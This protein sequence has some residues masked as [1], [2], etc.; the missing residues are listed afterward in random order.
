MNQQLSR[1]TKTLPATPQTRDFSIFLAK[2]TTGME[3][4]ADGMR[5]QIEESKLSRPGIRQALEA[6]NSELDRSLTRAAPQAIASALAAMFLR[7]PAS[8][9]APDQDARIAA[10]TSDLSQFPGW[11]IR[12]A[13][14]GVSGTFAPSSAELVNLARKAIQHV[15]MEQADIARV[16]NAETYRTET[17]EE[18]E[19]VERGFQETVAILKRV[20]SYDAGKPGE[21]TDEDCKRIAED[22]KA[23]PVVLPQMSDRLK[24]LVCKA[25]A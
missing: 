19:R 16:L 17:A 8:A 11:A 5:W 13:I 2:L 3:R 9:N 23:N 15:T 24:S 20:N 10:Y 14:N 6:R 22:M 21:L 4:T 25:H 12:T 7:F 18:R 1:T